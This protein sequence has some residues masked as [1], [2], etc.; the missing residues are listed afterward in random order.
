MEYPPYGRRGQARRVRYCP[1]ATRRSMM[2]RSTHRPSTTFATLNTRPVHTL[3]T[4]PLAGREESPLL[5]PTRPWEPISLSYKKRV[6]EVNEYIA[7]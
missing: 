3:L 7:I 1:I 5:Q 6:E 4:Y 2:E